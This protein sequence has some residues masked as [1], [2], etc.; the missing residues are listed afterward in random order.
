MDERRITA[1]GVEHRVVVEGPETAPTIALI[2]PAQCNLGVYSPLMP[3]LRER[4]G[5]VRYDFRGT[6]G[7]DGGARA[8]YNFQRYADDLAEIFDALGIERAI[9]VGS[10]YGARTAARFALRH[11]KRIALLA[12]FDVALSPPVDQGKQRELM[13]EA[14]R[15]RDEAGIGSPELDR[16]WFEHRHPKEALRSLTAHVRFA[17]PTEEMATVQIPT[18]V[19][20]GR[21]D[22][23]LVEAQRIAVLM[24]D[25]ELQVMEMTSH[26]AV[27]SRPLAMADLLLD[28]IERRLK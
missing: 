23:N 11:P 15:L 17:D 16:A 22:M 3:R 27:M 5:V 14:R 2:N 7:T 21:Q 8:D 10:A 26:P 24:P 19:A 9:V 6:G 13:L 12:L 28:F 18:L 20:C 25:A 1:G 4:F